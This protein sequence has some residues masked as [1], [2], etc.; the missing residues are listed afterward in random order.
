MDE[1]NGTNSGLLR[2]LPSV[3]KLLGNVRLREM[4]DEIEVP[5]P[6]LTDITRQ[7]LEIT[8]A[9]IL[10]GKLIDFSLDNLLD[11][12]EQDLTALLGQKLRPVINATGVV[13]HTNLG[14]APLSVEAVAMMSAISGQYN[15]LEFDLETGG[16]G[17]R[18]SHVSDLIAKATGAEA[19]IAV[20]NCASAVFFVLTA[21]AKGREVILSRSQAV[22]IGGGFRIPDVMSQ[23]GA[24]LVEVGTTNKTYLSDYASAITPDTAGL[25]RVHSSNFKVIGFTHE[26][27]LKE[28][29]QVANERDLILMDDLGSGS[30]LDTS[31]YGLS[32]EPMVQDSVAAGAHVIMFSGDKLLGGPQAG[33]IAGR[34]DLIDRLKKHPLARALRL[35]KMTL[36]ALQVTLQHYLRGEAKQKI[37]VWRM[38]AMPLTEIEQKAQAWKQAVSVDWA[39]AAVIEGLS[40]VGGGSLPG[41]TLP[42]KLLAIPA[43]DGAHASQLAT[44][45]RRQSPPVIA[46]V[47][48]D[49]LLFDPRTVLPEQETDLLRILHEIKNTGTQMNTDEHR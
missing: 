18:L 24:K 19:G 43:K 28:M 45:L 47:E 13:L 3:D 1:R 35:D 44:A 14:R 21:F 49:V 16:R 33:I 11:E 20:N 37:P 25:L 48:K 4:A 27:T 2:S 22:E 26:T 15:N 34:K 8:R 9:A 42:T 40:T 6:L 10:S 32:R 31:R 39:N 5:R 12:I 30:F 41:D 38:I 46:R 23:S 7:H 17:S 36:A 29:A